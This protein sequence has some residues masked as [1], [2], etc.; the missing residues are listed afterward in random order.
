MNHPLRR[1]LILVVRCHYF[2]NRSIENFRALVFLSAITFVMAVARPYLS[3]EQPSA[4][5]LSYLYGSGYG[6]ALDN[7][8]LVYL[9]WSW[10]TLYLFA[11]GL[12]FFFNWFARPLFL[13]TFALSI[14]QTSVAGLL[15]GEA[16]DNVIWT[17]QGVF[18]TFSIGMLFFSQ[19]VSI[20]IRKDW[21]NTINTPPPPATQATPILLPPDDGP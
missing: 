3:N 5:L 13:F 15:V 19:D 18:F 10:V 6:A 1:S 11:H 17:V 9:W 2:M 7:N 20:R 14:I 21:I 8:S 12:A 4:E 16:I